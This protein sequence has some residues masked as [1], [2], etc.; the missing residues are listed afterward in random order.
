MQL[1][2]KGQRSIGDSLRLFT[3]GE[4]LAGD[5]AVEVRQRPCS[6]HS[7]AFV[8]VIACACRWVPYALQTHPQLEALLRRHHHIQVPSLVP[9]LES[10]LARSRPPIPTLPPP[11]TPPTPY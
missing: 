8:D 9:G 1:E 5:N 10:S 2:V 3:E 4:V 6:L 7:R 11:H